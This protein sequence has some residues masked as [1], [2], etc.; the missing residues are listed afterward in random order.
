MSFTLIQNDNSQ[1]QSQVNT[2]SEL[3]SHEQDISIR[4]QA[5]SRF[6]SEFRKQ[7]LS[8]SKSKYSSLNTTGSV[9]ELLSLTYSNSQLLDFGVDQDWSA[10][11]DGK[12][13][14]EWRV[15]PEIEQH[16]A[17]Q[18]QK[19]VDLA[20]TDKLTDEIFN[21]IVTETAD[22]VVLNAPRK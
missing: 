2:E 6:N 11:F 15:H 4:G 8:I 22:L 18:T 10:D 20:M 9:P 1:A 21:I 13:K 17:E 16:L 5:I 14:T 7:V 19:V 3:I 12:L